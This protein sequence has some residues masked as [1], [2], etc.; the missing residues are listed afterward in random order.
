MTFFQS[1]IVA[2]GLLV[3][4]NSFAQCP[5]INIHGSKYELYEDAT[6]YADQLAEL[7][8]DLIELGEDVELETS[9]LPTN[10]E[11]L[12]FINGDCES[13]NQFKE[14]IWYNNGDI[15]FVDFAKRLIK[16]EE[17][18]MRFFLDAGYVEKAM[19][20]A[21][22]VLY[23]EE[24]FEI[25]GSFVGLFFFFL[26]GF[27]VRK[28][29]KTHNQEKQ[30]RKY[31]LQDA[32]QCGITRVTYNHRANRLFVKKGKLALLSILVTLLASLICNNASA[33]PKLSVWEGKTTKGK[34][35]SEKLS[36]FKTNAF[37]AEAEAKADRPL[38]AAKLLRTLE[39][40]LYSHCLKKEF[41]KA[42]SNKI[43]KAGKLV[44]NDMHV[45]EVALFDAKFIQVLINTGHYLTHGKSLKALAKMALSFHTKDGKLGLINKN[46][47]FVKEIKPIKLP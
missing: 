40:G 17:S 30:L 32:M 18:K 1:F 29:Q 2:F 9:T 4:F 28:I 41:K 34:C 19:N 47:V 33:A 22:E 20:A 25:K 39:V 8:Q 5:V 43:Q 7:K 16:V 26:V 45:T 11:N 36:I 37:T 24:I 44:V 13:L 12:T 14:T 27:L 38:Q 6:S 23:I 42:L 3:S 15:R 35:Q 46:H 10:S 31:E 21:D